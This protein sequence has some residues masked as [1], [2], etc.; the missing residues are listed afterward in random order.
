M[1][2]AVPLV[3][4]PGLLFLALSAHADRGAGVV[5]LALAIAVGLLGIVATRMT[6]DGVSGR[7]LGW[8]ARATAAA[9]VVA[10]V[11]LVIDGIF[12]V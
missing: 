3:A 8:T 10:A 7:I 5:A 6:A 1:P 11:L 12:A 4:G 2:V 9:A